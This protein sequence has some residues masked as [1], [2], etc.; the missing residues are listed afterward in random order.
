[1]NGGEW[2]QQVD[3]IGK[4]RQQEIGEGFQRGERWAFEAAARLYFSP[5]VQFVSHLLNDREKAVDLAQEAFFL[6]CRAHR[7]F[8][9]SLAFLPWL[10]QIA[11]NLAYKE[12]NR[13]K[14]EPE[15]SWEKSEEY[16]STAEETDGGD[17]RE[18][19]MEQE[20]MERIQRAASR[21]KPKYRD[22]LILRMMQGL[23]GEQVS[24]MLNI[25]IATVNTR[26][27]RALEHLRRYTKQESLSE[28]ELLI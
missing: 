24:E 20:V 28:S 15:V 8:D 7:K 4:Q 18:A 2:K 25:P 19:A 26:L 16:T 14:K 10:Y 3:S 27:F 12:Y 11:R 22:V 13:C 9:A 17:P 23:P 5:V 21:L 1:L 6:A